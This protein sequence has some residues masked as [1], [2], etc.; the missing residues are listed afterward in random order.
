[1]STSTSPTPRLI[2]RT[3][4]ASHNTPTSCWVILFG[5]VFNL[6]SFAA[7]HPAGAAL[8]HDRAGTDVSADFA[9][10]HG[11]ATLEKY[12]KTLCIGHLAPDPA[13]TGAAGGLFAGSKPR[14]SSGRGSGGSGERDTRLIPMSVSLPYTDP[15][16]M[17]GWVSPYYNDTHVLFRKHI[18]A[19]MDEHIAPYCRLWEEAGAV[20]REVIIKCAE[21]G[22]LPLVCGLPWPVDYVS[23]KIERDG[24]EYTSEQLD[25]FHELI[26]I[27]ESARVGSAGVLWAISGGLSIGL[28]PV[29]HF[30]SEEMKRRVLKPCLTGQ[31]GICLAITEASGGS[32]VAHLEC[33]AVKSDCGT[34]YTVNGHKKWITAGTTADYFTTAVRT[35]DDESGA[36]GV[37]L[38]LIERSF[39]GVKTTPVKVCHLKWASQKVLLFFNLKSKSH[40]IL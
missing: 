17:Q 35:G 20:P 30:G 5:K 28:P 2:S 37:S 9:R 10:F 32:D 19:F 16:Y 11:A 27:D 21:Q 7:I 38:L 23:D 12:A 34:Y 26:M 14:R 33:R 6:T 40:C 15:N 4:V 22:L 31:K 24:V 39:P 8:I 13:P 25:M 18:R 1:M 29:V 3:E 36:L